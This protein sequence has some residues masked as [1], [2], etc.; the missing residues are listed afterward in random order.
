MDLSPGRELGP[1]RL[2]EH[3]GR[4]GM[5]VVYKAYQATLARYVAVKVLPDDVAGDPSFRARFREEAISIAGLRHP[6]ILA[7]FDYGEIDG[8]AYIVTEFIDGGTLDQQLGSA[9]PSHYANDILR[10]I[11]AALDYAHSRGVIHRDVKPSNILLSRDGTPMLAD[12]G[13][14]RMMAPDREVT[15]AGMVLGTPNYMAPEQAVGSPE[16]ASDQYALAVVAYEML[17]GRVPYSA[18]TPMG[19]VIAHQTGPL[20]PPRSV[21]PDIPEDVEAALVKALDRDPKQRFASATAFVRALAQETPSGSIVAPPPAPPAAEPLAAFAAGAGGR[22]RWLIAGGAGLLVLL[23]IAGVAAYA[24]TRGTAPATTTGTTKT[25][26]WEQW[27][28]I[29][30]ILD[31]QPTSTQGQMMAIAN[32]KLSLIQGNQVLPFAQ[33]QG[34]F[35]GA[36]GEPYIAVSPGLNLS[37]CDFGQDQA[38]ALHEAQPLSI[39]HVDTHGQASQLAAIPGVPDLNGLVFDTVG[40]FGQRLLTVSDGQNDAALI[41]VDCQGHVSKIASSVPKIEGGLAVAPTSFGSFGGNLIGPDEFDGKIY[42]VDQNGQARVVVNSGLPSGQD[43]GV[44]SAG[45]V[46]NGFIGSKGAAYVADRAT[47][48]NVHPGT[49]TLLRLLASDLKDAGVQD[50]DLLVA[51]EGGGRTLDIRCDHGCTVREIGHATSGAHIEGHIVFIANPG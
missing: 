38:F 12:F 34:G 36:G 32:G 5:G 28:Q 1:Y 29:T 31:V 2:V 7:V 13:L 3:V 48:N 22:R 4:G 37:G 19:V 39:T 11:A 42:A 17:T 49:D 25:V 45:F 15:S 26:T 51:T 23:L 43:T 24:L 8:G 46:P 47:G 30:G 27:K 9:L 44:E 20:P 10:P 18:P 35:T 6:N 33:A 41:A 21:N 50:G 40:K 14:A 16:P